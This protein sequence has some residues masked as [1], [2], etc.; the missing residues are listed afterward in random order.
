LIGKVKV[1]GVEEMMVRVG[2]SLPV[3][4]S[5]TRMSSVI[6]KRRTGKIHTT[7]Q[8]LDIASA[9]GG[10]ICR[11]WGLVGDTSIRCLRCFDGLLLERNFGSGSCWCFEGSG[12]SFG[13]R[14]DE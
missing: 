12:N 9:V 13:C 10:V 11:F 5:S 2:S 6:V 7:G 1:H 14:F 8:L 3:D 4:T